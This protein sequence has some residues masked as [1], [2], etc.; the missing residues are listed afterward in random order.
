MLYEGRL[1]R[2]V[3]INNIKPWASVFKDGILKKRTRMAVFMYAVK[4]SSSP[5]EVSEQGFELIIVWRISV[6]AADVDGTVS[7]KLN[8]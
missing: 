2:L 4:I 1:S 5:S 3:I 8:I 7:C 6:T